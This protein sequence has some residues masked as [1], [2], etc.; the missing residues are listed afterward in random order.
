MET[1]GWLEAR[2]IVKQPV[3][4]GSKAFLLNRCI[5]RFKANKNLNWVWGKYVKIHTVT[6]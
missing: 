1:K 4:Y 2:Q 5:V 3:S 6:Y